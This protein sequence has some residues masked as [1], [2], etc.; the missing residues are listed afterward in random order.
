VNR[1]RGWVKTKLGGAEAFAEKPFSAELSKLA[2]GAKQNAPKTQMSRGTFADQPSPKCCS[3]RRVT[4]GRVSVNGTSVP[5]RGAGVLVDASAIWRGCS[6]RRVST[7]VLVGEAGYCR[8]SR[9]GWTPRGRLS[10]IFVEGGRLWRKTKRP[11][12]RLSRGTLVDQPSPKCCSRR[13]IREE[14][15]GVNGTVVL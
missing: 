15:G 4:L 6:R 13:S 14:R 9:L 2:F 7:G 8:D 3:S 10:H 1:C 11:G 12:L 5:V